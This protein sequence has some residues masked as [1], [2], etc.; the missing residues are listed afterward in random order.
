MLPAS[1]GPGC[2]AAWG[3]RGPPN[4]A[5]AQ[6]ALDDLH[7][8]ALGDQLTAA[9]M[10]HLVRGVPRDAGR[11]DQAGRGAEI[12]PLVMERVV[13]HSGAPVRAEHQ[14][15]RRGEA[16]PGSPR[17]PE[18][19]HTAWVAVGP[20][21]TA[22]S[23]SFLASRTRASSSAWRRRPGPPGRGPRAATEQHVLRPPRGMA[24]ALG[25]L[26]G[27]VQRLASVVRD[28]CRS[29]LIFGAEAPE[30]RQR[31]H[32][33]GYASARDLG[34]SPPTLPLLC[35]SCELLTELV[36]DAAAVA[37]GS[38]HGPPPA[39]QP[40][41]PRSAAT[42]RA[43]RRPG[44]PP[45]LASVA[46]DA[47]SRRRAGPPSVGSAVP[48]GSSVQHARHPSPPSSS[49]RSRDPAKRR[50][51]ARPAELTIG[52]LAPQLT[53]ATWSGS[54]HAQSA[55]EHVRLGR[56]EA[57]GDVSLDVPPARDVPLLR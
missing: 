2:P 31:S 35:T 54:L 32:S 7:A 23:V 25:L 46:G 34:A 11:V 12:G 6:H 3:S 57:G 30:A 17:D 40:A 52:P 38:P 15:V 39:T 37:A 45:S 42:C 14:F 26:L 53:W 13:R 22:R 24:K 4:G 1:H 21:I 9:G 19:A 33:T 27:Q 43:C 50:G 47:A 5:M 29:L 16:L 55:D 18:P 36:I 48:R 56:A 8:L 51:Q 28:G 10:A 41:G 44:G 49:N 20:R